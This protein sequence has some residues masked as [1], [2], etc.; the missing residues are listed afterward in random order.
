MRIEVYQEVIKLIRLTMGP[1]NP[2]IGFLAISKKLKVYL[3]ID[4]ERFCVDLVS[5]LGNLTYYL[6]LSDIETIFR[7]VYG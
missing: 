5:L 6:T 3:S 1:I 7:L 2:H 4:F